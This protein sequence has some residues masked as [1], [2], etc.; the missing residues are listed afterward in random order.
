MGEVRTGELDVGDLIELELTTIAHGGH[1]IAHAQ[2]RTLLVRHGL[3]GERVLARV[4]AVASKVSRADAVQIL[5]ASPR[6]VRPV[7][8][9]FQPGGCGGCDFQHADLG[10]QRELKAQVIADAF[11][12]HA[13]MPDLAVAVEPLAD[14]ADLTGGP[15][16]DGWHWRTRM[17]WQVDAR[18]VVGLHPHRSSEVIGVTRCLIAAE[19]IDEPPAAAG[20]R[21]LEL[22][23][24][25]DM[26]RSVVGTDGEVTVLAGQDVIRGKR[27][28]QQRVRDRIWRVDPD[29]FWQ[30]HP[31]AAP[32][33][34][35][36]VLRMATPS[37]GE[38]WWDLFTGAGL[39]AA[40][41]A[42]AVG[43]QGCVHAVEGSAQ[44]VRDARRSLHDL[45]QIRLHHHEVGRWL[46]SAR[47][48]VDGVVLDPARTGLGVKAM[49]RLAAV[50]PRVIVYVACDPVSLARDVAVA[51][52]CGY[53]LQEL[54]AF[55]AF[56]MT[57]HVELVAALVPR[58]GVDEIS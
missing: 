24:G 40:F 12:R 33:L 3:P 36:T 35:D 21:G 13:S 53:R 57:H 52:E 42:K 11:R 44:A 5:R 45:P 20:L 25:V 4:T 26:L 10:Y 49:A 6:R 23:A 29:T 43:P 16:A 7:C 47:E 50:G 56:A 51:A 55:D 30:S 2:G 18:G 22:P 28:S 8:P 48:P 32:V 37:I 17:R 46:E 54:R 1:C 9:H 38:S 41:L 39:F 58:A 15:G 27:R 19:G 14:P 34:V 31:L